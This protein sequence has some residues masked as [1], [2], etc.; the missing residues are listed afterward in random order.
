MKE[1]ARGRVDA[2]VYDAPLLRWQIKREH[3]GELR[4]LPLQLERQDYAFALPGGSP[5]RESL[6]TSLLQRIN[7]ADWDQ[8]LKKYFGS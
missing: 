6:N 3:P 1:L 2:I 4:V 7:A 8:R 5:L